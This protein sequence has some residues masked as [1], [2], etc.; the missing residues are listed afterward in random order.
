MKR[1][2]G[3]PLTGAAEVC[4]RLRKRRWSLLWAHAN[5]DAPEARGP[6]GRE[7]LEK[8][9]CLSLNTPHFCRGPERPGNPQIR[10]LTRIEVAPASC[11]ESYLTPRPSVLRSMA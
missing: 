10:W 8:R 4:A 11:G 3:G 2:G 6:Q 1:G 9:D 7:L 5:P